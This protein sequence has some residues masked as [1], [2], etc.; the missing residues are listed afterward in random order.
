MTTPLEKLHNRFGYACSKGN[1]T[2]VQN[3]LNDPNPKNKIDIN[4]NSNMMKN[5][6]L[7]Q[8]IENKHPQIAKVLLQVPGINVH[9]SN[10]YDQTALSFACRNGYTDI[11]ETLLKHKNIDVNHLSGFFFQFSPLMLAAIH[12]HKK[13]VEMLLHMPKID[14]NAKSYPRQETVL[15]CAAEAGNTRIIELLLKNPRLDIMMEK[16]DGKTAY[17]VAVEY[18]QNEAAN[19]LQEPMKAYLLLNYMNKHHTVNRIRATLSQQ[20]QSSSQSTTK[21]RRPRTKQSRL[22][23]GVLE[24]MTKVKPD[25]LYQLADIMTGTDHKVL[26]QR[27]QNQ[28]KKMMEKR[29]QDMDM[30]HIMQQLQKKQKQRLK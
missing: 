12:G 13:I 25:I 19:L 15:H 30:T 17:D 7:I 16:N 18:K 29:F 26:H 10:R 4:W 23:K 14:I 22:R 8:A 24:E 3:F 6:F 11:V 20:P 9:L 21:T 1:L 5:T 28:T 2:D 27:V